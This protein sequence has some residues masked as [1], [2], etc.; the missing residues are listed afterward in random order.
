[1]SDH[2][3]VLVIPGYNGSGPDHWQT[4]W[5]WARDDCTRVVQHSW[6]DPEP[7]AWVGAIAAAVEAAAGTVVIAAHSLG[8]IA[9]AH[10][11]AVADTTRVA[12]ALLVAPCDVERVGVPEALARFAPIPRTALPFRSV[13]VASSNDPYATPA[14]S[15][16]LAEQWGASLVEA[17]ALGHINAASQLG[18]WPF[19]QALLDDLIAAGPDPRFAR[20]AALRDAAPW[21][22]SGV[23]A[24]VRP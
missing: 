2:P 18:A 1:M 17:G 16:C 6:H 13:V 23:S 20:A 19:G 22:C 4:H 3:R 14:R 10:W 5:E 11:A 12:G 15:R 7:G 9:V 8:C 24:A 21:P